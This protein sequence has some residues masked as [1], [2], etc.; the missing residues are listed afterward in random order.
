MGFQICSDSH[1]HGETILKNDFPDEYDSLRSALVEVDLPLRPSEPFTST[2][3][4]LKPKR[5]ARTIG[6]R[7]RPALF[8][9]DLPELNKVIERALN[10]DGWTSQPI[11]AGGI[12]PADA[13]LLGL[14]GDFVRRSV[15]VEVEFGNVA[16][17]H[18]DLFKFHIASRA[19]VG[20]VGILVT[21]TDKLARFHDQGVT[22]FEGA[23]RVRPYMSIGIQMP[24]WI[25][26]IEPEDWTPLKERYEEMHAV[27]DANGVQCHAFPTV[28]GIEEPLAAPG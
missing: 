19:G 11:A 21:A 28:F 15:F 7:R 2:G 14:R 10:E 1:M 27:C 18:R 3:R 4:P 16:S 23:M 26:G 5:Q 9:A 25:I 20:D 24:I 17:L 8:P 13:T 12:N 6:G 22:T